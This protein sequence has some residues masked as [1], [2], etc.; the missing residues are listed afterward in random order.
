[1]EKE[2]GDP[3]YTKKWFKSIDQIFGDGH[4]LI[5]NPRWPKGFILEKFI[6]YSDFYGKSILEIGCKLDSFVMWPRQEVLYLQ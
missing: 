4:S 5:N 2:L 1:M 6:P 3:S